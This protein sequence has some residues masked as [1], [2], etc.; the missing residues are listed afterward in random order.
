VRFRIIDA[1]RPLEIVKK[2]VE[3]IMLTI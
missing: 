1:D 2:S 3:D